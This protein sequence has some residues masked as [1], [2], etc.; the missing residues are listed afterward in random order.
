LREQAPLAGVWQDWKDRAL[1]KLRVQVGT[2]IAAA[3]RKRTGRPQSWAVCDASA[4]VSVFLFEG[5]CAIAAR[6][7]PGSGS[8]P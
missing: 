4:L 5:C 3:S 6:S 2:E 7:S 1:A 8:R